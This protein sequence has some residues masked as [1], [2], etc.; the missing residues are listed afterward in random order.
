MTGTP[1]TPGAPFSP[2]VPMR[3]GIR[4][5]ISVPAV[6]TSDHG[7]AA[8]ATSVPAITAQQHMHVSTGDRIGPGCYATSGSGL[9]PN[10]VPRT[11]SVPSRRKVHLISLAGGRLNRPK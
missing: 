10:E 5:R 8:Y 2:V 1:C 9:A 7:V 3:P 11:E 4:V 6:A